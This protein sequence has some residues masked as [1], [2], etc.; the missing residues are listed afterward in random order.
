MAIKKNFPE[1]KMGTRHRHFC[2]EDM[3]MANRQMKKMLNIANYQK[4]ANE[5]YNKVP[6]YT[7]QNVHH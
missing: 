1:K 5:N 7:G 6:P 4:N 2:K 3:Q